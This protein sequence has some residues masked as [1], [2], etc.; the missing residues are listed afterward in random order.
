MGLLIG[1]RPWHDDG[2]SR[3][4]EHGCRLLRVLRGVFTIARPHPVRGKRR[5]LY[6][7]IEPQLRGIREVGGN[8]LDVAEDG[9]VRRGS[10]S[11]AMRG[12][13][14]A[15]RWAMLDPPRKVIQRRGVSRQFPVL[16][17]CMQQARPARRHVIRVRYL[18]WLRRPSLLLGGRDLSRD[19]DRPDLPG[20][21]S[22]RS[23]MCRGVRMRGR[24]E[25][26]GVGL[27]EK[28]G[29]GRQLRGDARV[30][31]SA[32]APLH[33]QEMSAQDSRGAR[34][35]VHP[36]GSHMRPRLPMQHHA[37]VTDPDVRGCSGGRQPLHARRRT[38]PRAGHLLGGHLQA[39][40]GNQLPVVTATW[41]CWA[42]ETGSI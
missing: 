29:R 41:R 19:A 21:P 1:Q 7:E 18:W 14:G 28:R 17:R 27:R 4:Q 2:R 10:P 26:Q 42:R 3:V 15:Q 38:V 31:H 33:R 37:F 8:Q 36:A 32:G 11:G 22:R 6:G 40:R 24:F 30:R 34:C 12:S 20:A 16:E 25:L 23:T 5:Y 39:S 9:P 13:S 35:S